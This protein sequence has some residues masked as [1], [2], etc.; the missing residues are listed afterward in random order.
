M[1]WKIWYYIIILT[2]FFT[3]YAQPEINIADKLEKHVAKYVAI[4]TE[5]SEKASKSSS[6]I[7]RQ[8]MKKYPTIVVNPKKNFNE[9]K[10]KNFPA[11]QGMFGEKYQREVLKVII[12]D[13]V[14]SKNTTQELV[15]SIDFLKNFTAHV[16]RPKT[17]IILHVKKNTYLVDFFKYCWSHKF[18]YVTVIEFI[19]KQEKRS[20][21]LSSKKNYDVLAHQYNPFDDSI[22]SEKFSEKIELFSEKLSDLKKF[23]LKGGV[24]FEASYLEFQKSDLDLH[25]M[26]S[27][28]RVDVEFAKTTLEVMNAKID[29]RQM[30]LI[31]SRK[32]SSNLPKTKY[33]NMT[34]LRYDEIDY[35]I[36]WMMTV[37]FPTSVS[38]SQVSNNAMFGK[39][40][41]SG[42]NSL[43]LKQYGS[44]EVQFSLILVIALA[45]IIL[46]VFALIL[47][48]KFNDK[49]WTIYNITKI[50]LGVNI[51]PEPKKISDRMFFMV[52]VFVYSVFFTDVIEKTFSVYNYKEINTL[53]DVVESGL[54][55]YVNERVKHE[56]SMS[57]IESDRKFA[58]LSI[59]YFKRPEY[60]KCIKGLLE[61][62]AQKYNCCEIRT[63][64]GMQIA[65]KFLN[66][67]KFANDD[68]RLISLIKEAFGPMYKTM[69]HSS[70]SPYKPRIN[71]IYQR[72]LETGIENLWL[73]KVRR[74]PSSK[75]QDIHSSMIQM[76]ET[77][78]KSPS[79]IY[80]VILGICY[81]MSILIFFFEISCAWL[82][83]KNSRKVFPLIKHKRKV[84]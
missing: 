65:Q 55:P 40:H 59:P 67:Q 18:L 16:R 75:D 30:E 66:N 64:M 41:I 24:E 8:I 12:I 69:F 44:L 23:T 54:V 74:V 58:K 38:P 19:E 63:K 21:F 5:T 25:P 49:V 62:G 34:C 51:R 45:L 7:I 32:H 26:K 52:L 56:L 68:Y 27:E 6:S 61:E 28:I 71:Q 78:R 15:N 29:F 77:N 2:K 42:S 22:H 83:R 17:I 79:S 43:L 60:A 81:A 39:I 80:M 70:V 13:A 46:C 35:K 9:T 14:N 57:G 84:Y 3:V 31:P 20:P 37:F 53:N 82:T 76:N 72:L 36:E 11:L 47:R 1:D 4:I 50:F 48:T 33:K 73:S 10:N